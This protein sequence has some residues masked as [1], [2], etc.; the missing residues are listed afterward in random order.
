M[1]SAVE[2]PVE[3][4]RGKGAAALVASTSHVGRM[5]VQAP[6]DNGR[7]AR[8]GTCALYTVKGATAA[9][10][11]NEEAKDDVQVAP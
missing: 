5:L 7:W 9:M 3:D 2:A 6:G 10:E 4:R 11:H 1:S 8:R